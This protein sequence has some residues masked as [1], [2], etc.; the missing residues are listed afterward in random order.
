VLIF[1]QINEDG[2]IRTRDH[3]VIK[4]LIPCQR[5]ISTQKLKLLGEVSGYDLYYS[6][7]VRRKGVAKQQYKEAPPCLRRSGFYLVVFYQTLD[8]NSLSFL[9][10]TYLNLFG[11]NI[12]KIE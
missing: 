2:E 5:T 9:F 4:A 1:Y 8:K 12:N 11:F 3:L 10:L 7:T 6:L